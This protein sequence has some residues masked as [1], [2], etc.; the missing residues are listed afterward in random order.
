MSVNSESDLR[1]TIL[2][3]SPDEDLATS[4]SLLLERR[5]RIVRETRLEN[6]LVTIEETAPELLLM[7][8]YS[9]PSD[10]RRMLDILSGLKRRIP[11]ITLHVYRQHNP[12]LERTIQE[13]SDVVLFKPLRV[14]ELRQAV[15][16]VLRR[17]STAEAE[18]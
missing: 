17:T 3:F 7:D 11:T 2:V 12:E 18:S 16:N 4:L 14:E 9:F 13:I 5:F 1:T 15:K 10:T 6:L 8:L